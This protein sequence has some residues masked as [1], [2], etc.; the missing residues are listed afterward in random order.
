MSCHNVNGVG[1]YGG[2]TIG[3]DL[4]IASRFGADGVAGILSG[5]PYPTMQPIYRNKMLTKEEQ[6]HLAAFLMSIPP[7]APAPFPWKFLGAVAVGFLFFVA[8]PAVVWRRRNRGIRQ[9]L[10]EACRR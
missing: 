7:A 1:R 4:T 8:T 5:L 9:P 10:V 6:A 3:P 2:G